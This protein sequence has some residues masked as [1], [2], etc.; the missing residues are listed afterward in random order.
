V[1]ALWSIIPYLNRFDLSAAACLD[2]LTQGPEHRVLLI[3]KSQDPEIQRQ[4][5]QFASFHHPRVLLWVQDPPL[6][7]L[8]AT[9]NQALDFAWETGGTEALV[10]NND[11]R[12]SETNYYLLSEIM[13][14]EGALFVTATGVTEPQFRDVLERGQ[15]IRD[16]DGRLMKG[17][18]GFSN[19][20]ISRECHAKY[21]FDEALIPAFCEDVDYHRRMMLGGD[22][23]R[24]FGT[25]VV[26][27]HIGG[28][29]ASSMSP[30][31][32][33]SLRLRV[34]AGSRAHYL[35]KWGGPVNEEKFWVPFSVGATAPF[36]LRLDDNVAPM[37]T[38][39]LYDRERKLWNNPPGTPSG[40]L[41]G[42]DVVA[43][44]EPR[45]DSARAADGE[46]Y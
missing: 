8:S 42:K 41:D 27:L 40:G 46:T 25:N 19:F 28:Q 43:L 20:L 9:W 15:S 7:S 4:S 36:E 17:G 16:L 26:Y 10:L 24:I 33:E 23:Q 29:T 21:R 45:D 1:S 31:Q 44:G 3:D 32:Q 5:R 38:P 13:R 39:E 12:L 30:E 34:D 18:P 37:T 22:G 14:E 2:A 35:R 6:T 11:V